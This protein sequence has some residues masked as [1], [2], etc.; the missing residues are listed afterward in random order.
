MRSK[1]FTLIEL[2]AVIVILAIIALVA[3]PIVLNI[4]NDASDSSERESAEIYLH[5]VELEITKPSLDSNLLNVTCEVQPG[6]YLDCEGT[7]VPI[8]MNNKEVVKGGTLTIE[9]GK[10]TRVEG[11]KINKGTY[12]RGADGKIVKVEN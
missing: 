5:T 9:N 2:L 1:G 4:I 11:L 8:Q 10:I 3:T 7:T 12:N 6:G